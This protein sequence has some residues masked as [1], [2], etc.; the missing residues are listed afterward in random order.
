MPAPCSNNTLTRP[1]QDLATSQAQTYETDLLN[2]KSA[3]LGDSKVTV[4]DLERGKYSDT[5]A[6][7]GMNILGND[8]VTNLSAA[9]AG[10]LPCS[11]SEHRSTGNG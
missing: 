7:P 2:N 1:L 5:L 3:P 11:P 4:D 10:A 6:S 9:A 8:T